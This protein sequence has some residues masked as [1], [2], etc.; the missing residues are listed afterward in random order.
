MS[1]PTFAWGFS[2]ADLTADRARV[3]TDRLVLYPGAY[4]LAVDGDICFCTTLAEANEAIA[5]GRLWRLAII[6]DERNVADPPETPIAY[7]DRVKPIVAAFASAG[8]PTSA[9]AVGLAHGLP[10]AMAWAG[11]V[12]GPD[13]R[14]VNARLAD[15]PGVLRAITG[16]PH[17]YVITAIVLRPTWWPLRYNDI[18]A[19]LNQELGG[20]PVA[21]LQDALAHPNVEALAIWNLRE[22][23]LANG[24]WQTWT[25]MLDHNGN[26]TSA[27][28]LV[29]KALKYNAKV[30]M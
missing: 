11:F 22:G 24:D 27:H 10:A 2:Q 17:K 5:T 23:K 13:T 9:A 12:T 14:G 7:S 28:G 16:R 25:G 4:H 26:P 1:A 21:V 3:P 18:L 20:H 6:D 29:S 19:Y 8:I 30:G 15:L